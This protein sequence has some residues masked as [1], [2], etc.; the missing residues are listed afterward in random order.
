MKGLSTP[1]IQVKHHVV[2]SYIVGE[3]SKKQHM[4]H[5]LATLRKMNI[6]IKSEYA[7][8]V[9]HILKS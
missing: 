2:Q 6:P 1:I 4:E 8:A 7:Q 9:G 3:D 5:A